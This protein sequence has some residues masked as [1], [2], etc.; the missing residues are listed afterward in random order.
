M[1]TPADTS[2]SVPA[3]GWVVLVVLVG[4]VAG[5]ALALLG[6]AAMA[7]PGPHSGP[8]PAVSFRAPLFVSGL[9]LVLVLALLGV[10]VRTFTE[11][12]ARFA[13]GL[14][15]V[16]FALFFETLVTSPAVFGAFGYVPGNLGFFFLLGG[17]FEA[18]AF[19][20]FLYLSLE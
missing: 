17:I 8:A 6:P 19:A 13:L 5:V 20:V 4:V 9:D 10:Y 16:L 11:T 14:V 15:V 12:R 7:P 3:W 18:A 1:S 2:R